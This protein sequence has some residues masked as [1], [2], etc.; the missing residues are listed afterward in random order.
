MIAGDGDI[1]D[2]DEGDMIFDVGDSFQTSI[3]F[4]W[5]AGDVG[6][7]GDHD[8]VGVFVDCGKCRCIDIAIDKEGVVG[9]LRGE[10]VELIP[11]GLGAIEIIIYSDA[12]YFHRGDPLIRVSNSWDTYSDPTHRGKSF[13]STSLSLGSDRV[14]T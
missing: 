6:V 10:V 12:D 4:C 1:F 14:V 7:S 8:L 9:V 2:S 13:G 5:G 11:F 3:E